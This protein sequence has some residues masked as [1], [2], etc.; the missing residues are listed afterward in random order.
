M[1]VLPEALLD[2]CGAFPALGRP[3]AAPCSIRK[4]MSGCEQCTGQPQP[5]GCK[6]LGAATRMSTAGVLLKTWHIR[7]H[8]VTCGTP[9]LAPPFCTACLG[10]GFGYSQR[11][12]ESS[13]STAAHGPAA[14]TAAGWCLVVKGRLRM[15]SISAQFLT[16]LPLHL[17]CHTTAALLVPLMLPMA[18]SFCFISQSGADNVRT[19]AQCSAACSLLVSHTSSY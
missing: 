14:G 9:C 15:E 1:S 18:V 5:Q 3:G 8:R 6:Q 10:W 7:G 19:A 4:A 2:V 11:S 12:A 13:P 16:R 17:L